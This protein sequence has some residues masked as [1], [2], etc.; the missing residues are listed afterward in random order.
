MVKIVVF[1]NQHILIES[2]KILFEIKDVNLVAV[3]G[4]ENEQDKMFGYSSVKEFCQKNSIPYYNPR[5]LDNQFLNLFAILNP[6]LCFSIYYRNIF[7]PDF[8]SIPSMG[9]INIHPSL[10]PK[11]RG[12][13][14]TLWALLNNDKKTGVT[15]HY[16]DSGIDTGD[17]IAQ[18]DYDIP[19]QITG[20]DLHVA[21]MEKGIQLFKRQLPLI[22]KNKNKRTKQN[23]G[24]ATYF[25]SFNQRL[26]IIN[27]YVPVEK[28][29][30]KI[31]V[32][33]KPYSGAKS[34][35]LDKEIVLW[36]A[37]I[38]THSKQKLSG[39]GKIIMAK[40]R[41]FVVSG[42]DGFLLIKNFEL[43][44]VSKKSENKYIKVGNS[45]NLT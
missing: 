34:V 45:F 42:V 31:Q 44:D 32:L 37:K 26:R 16:I 18:D 41:E 25:G 10:L 20:Y 3:V 2:I 33:T 19:K 14:P 29:N 38:V 4:C 22:L 7:T 12:P 9:F 8:I 1:G 21:L 17:I 5:K 35:I 36:E 11:Y 39:P 43:V 24:N 6:D 23:H 28:V 40:G 13:V 27:W 30:R 15:L